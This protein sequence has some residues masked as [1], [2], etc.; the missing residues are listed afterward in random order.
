[1]NMVILGGN[2]CMKHEYEAICH[3][4]GY[5]VKIFNRL[6][7]DLRRR[8]GD[9]DLAVVFT[10]TVSHALLGCALCSLRQS[11]AVLERCHS[12]SASALKNI[13]RGHC[14]NCPHKI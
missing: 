2:T 11:H 4:Y 14:Q 12:S 6:S 5:R 7:G 1:M 9:P 10:A 3:E 13:L 8:I